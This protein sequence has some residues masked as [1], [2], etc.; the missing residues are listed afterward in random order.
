MVEKGAYLL[1]LQIKRPIKINAGKFKDIILPAGN[2]VYVGSARRGIAQRVARHKRLAESKKG[3]LHWH[4]DSLLVHAH[5]QLAGEEALSERSECDVSK[6]LASMEGVIAPILGFGS[7]DCRSGCKA[8]L[9]RLDRRRPEFLD[10]NPY[11]ETS[12][13]KRNGSSN[14]AA[15]SREREK[16]H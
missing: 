12:K 15:L 13:E 3:K 7:S 16:I 10:L 14:R 2:Y 5:T 4:I 6:Q 1:Y 9:Y 8:H 11:P